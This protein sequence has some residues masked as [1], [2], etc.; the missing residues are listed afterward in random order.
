MGYLLAFMKWSLI[1]VLI[2]TGLFFTLTG[3]GVD[4][5]VVQW[6]GFEANNLPAGIA[7]LLIGLAVAYFWRINYIYA[8][9]ESSS[10]SMSDGTEKI[11]RKV[12]S[13]TRFMFPPKW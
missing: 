1:L 7:I 3:F 11:T 13:Q 4:V 10:K 2:L 6:K 9:E 12:R 5:P 8:Y